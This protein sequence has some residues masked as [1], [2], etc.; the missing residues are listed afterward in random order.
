MQ[1]RMNSSEKP[2][3]R[4]AALAWGLA[5]DLLLCVLG[6]NGPLAGLFRSPI[7]FIS[8]LV[9]VPFVLLF[10][11]SICNSPRYRQPN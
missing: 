4:W 5:I 6:V 7:L 10:W 3:S 2:I 11:I 8:I 1:D 9:L